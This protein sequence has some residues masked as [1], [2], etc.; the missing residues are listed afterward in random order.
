MSTSR[1]IQSV[2]ALPIVVAL[3]SI[4][5]ACTT[6]ATGT[7]GSPAPSPAAT[8]ASGPSVTL[9]PVSAS[10]SAEPSSS[11]PASSPVSSAA[12][13]TAVPTSIDPCAIVTT[14]EVEGLT[15]V[16]VT[17]G[18]EKTDT[19]NVKRCTYGAEGV[20]FMVTAAVAPDAATAKQ[21][22][23]AT[24][25]DLETQADG[26][27]FKVTELPGFAT[28]TDAAVVEGSASLGGAKF[29]GVAI[30]VLR[31]TTF[32]AISDISTLGVKV[33]T[34]TQIEDQAKVTLGRVP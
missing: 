25:A 27:P 2:A 18:Q 17:A 19:D 12:E 21:D 22:E 16:H 6:G 24:K 4:L 26:L 15:G 13:A 3:V 11:E 28:G 23:A 33:P 5:A 29:A 1:G 7:T 32:F 9:S 8:E 14:A 20:V 34:A 10:P 31:G 30:Y